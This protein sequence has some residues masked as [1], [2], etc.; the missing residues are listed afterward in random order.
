VLAN[1][2]IE[3][4]ESLFEKIAGNMPVPVGEAMYQTRWELANKGNLL[5]L[6]YSLYCLANLHV[7]KN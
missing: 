3:V 7:T 2:A 1:V 4:A 5:G 6:A